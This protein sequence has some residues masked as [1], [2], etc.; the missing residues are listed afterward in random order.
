[1]SVKPGSGQRIRISWPTPD[2]PSTIEA[3]QIS[4]PA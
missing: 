1:L 2:I 4:P 3:T